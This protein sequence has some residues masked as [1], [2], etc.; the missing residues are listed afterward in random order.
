[1]P[2]MVG[3]IFYE[4]G[5]RMVATTVGFL[6]VI[7]AVWLWRKESRKSL[8]ILGLVALGAVIL[9]GALGGLTVIL[10][11]PTAVSASHA[12]LAQT[13][14]WIV[15]SIALLTSKWWLTTP[16]FFNV[17][18][19]IP[20]LNS[21]IIVI[22]VIYI[23]LMLGA[24]MRHMDSGLAVPDFPLAYGQ[25]LPSLSTESLEQ[26]NKTLIYD[27]I[28]LAAEGPISSGQIM[29][30]LFH[31]YWALVVTGGIGLLVF[32]LRK[33]TSLVLRTLASLLSL[34]V[35]A[36]LSLGAWTVLSRKAVGIATAHVG[37]GALLLVGTVF[38]TL[39]IARL[40]GH[41]L[42]ERFMVKTFQ[43][44]Q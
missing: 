21:C 15:S 44:K 6:T 29:I 40:T 25:V 12:T 43:R 8:R 24:I 28:R 9:Q 2:P 3:G 26:Y 7:L 10:L 39:C 16:K 23:Q 38:I 20:S 4:H 17:N 31:R 35:V 42:V 18:D 36:Q 19:Q 34:L 33:T 30:H 32:Q 14:F 22:S 41:H 13:F 5:H 11:L 37:T 1:M 27:D